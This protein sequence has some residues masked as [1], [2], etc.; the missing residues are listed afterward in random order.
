MLIN[1]W[2]IAEANAQQW[3]VVPDFSNI[4]NNSEWTSGSLSPALKKSTNGFKKLQIVLLV[5]GPDREGVLKNCSKILSILKAPADFKLDNFQHKFYGV[6]TTYSFQENPLKRQR[7]TH[8]KI[9]Q[10]TLTVSC[11]EYE[12]QEDGTPFRESSSGKNE[13]TIINPGNIWTPCTVEITPQVGAAEMVING[14]S[15]NPETEE[16]L[17]VV[18]RNLT[19][20]NTVTLNGDTGIFS[21]NGKN[22]AKDIDI[23]TLPMLVPG[24]NVITLDNTWMDIVIEYRPRFM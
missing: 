21:E 18:V 2:D 15:R 8:N 4:K 17:S 3:N 14:I 9:S 23:W 7:V 22:K 1:G 24:E 20:G 10:L 11:Y 13:L 19:A 5:R 12:V 16:G 6:L